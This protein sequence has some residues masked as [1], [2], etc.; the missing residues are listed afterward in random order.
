MI[1]TRLVRELAVVSASAPQRSRKLSAASG[2]VRAGGF[3]YVAADDEN[4]IGVFPA[5]G[6]ADGR[7]V[8]IFEGELPHAHK[9]RKKTKPDQ[10]ALTRLPAFPGFPSGALMAW[11]SGSRPTRRSGAL[12]ALDAEGALSG[13]SQE[14][15]LS[16]LYTALEDRFPELNIEGA[17][18]CGDQLMLLQR[19]SRKAPENACIRFPLA[20]LLESLGNG[21]RVLAPRSMNVAIVDLGSIAGIALAFTDATDLPDGR[22]VFT[23][24]AENTEDSYQD[25]PCAGSAVGLIAAEGGIDWIQPL[26]GA[27][28]VEG[29]HAAIR[30]ESIEVLMVTD[31]DDAAIPAR[32]LAAELDFAREAGLPRRQPGRCPAGRGPAGVGRHRRLRAGAIH[33]RRHRELPAGELLRVWVGDEEVERARACI[34]RRG[35]HRWSRT[36]SILRS[37]APGPAPGRRWRRKATESSFVIDCWRPGPSHSANTTRFGICAIV[38]CC[39]RKRPGWP[40]IRVKS[41]SRSGSTMRSTS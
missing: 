16:G 19:G 20:G 8:R 33:E 21:G 9:A 17:V 15:D 4:H 40:C 3:L 22:I 39:S 11:G 24:V 32:L 5:E 27:P 26:D 28:K 10:E 29:I 2:L 18:V 31:A 37:S 7:L 41:R 13:P 14:V 25:G 6:G 38:S 12:L 30:G 1:A 36:R 34:A 35:A 23:A